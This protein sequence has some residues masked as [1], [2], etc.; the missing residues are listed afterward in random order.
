MYKNKMYQ[1]LYT[2]VQKACPQEWN[3]TTQLHTE[4]LKE[5][6]KEKEDLAASYEMAIDKFKDIAFRGKFK[7]RSFLPRL[8]NPRQPEC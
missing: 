8:C 7:L 3:Q 1:K 4:R 2:A 6:L 5:E